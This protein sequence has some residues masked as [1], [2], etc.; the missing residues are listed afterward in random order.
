M[1]SKIAMMN[2]L[3]AIGSKDDNGVLTLT[4]ENIEMFMS[5]KHIRGR[6]AEGIK[7][8]KSRK[9]SGYNLFMRES[10]M[11]IIETA[12]KW[13]GLSDEE[14]ESFNT[15]A[16]DMEPIMKEKVVKKKRGGPRGTSSYHL[17][18]KENREQFRAEFPE[19]TSGKGAIQKFCAKR[20]AQLK[21]DN[22]PIVDKF[23][24]LALE[25]RE[26]AEEPKEAEEPEEPEEPKEPEEPEDRLMSEL[27]IQKIIE[28][29][30]RA[31]QECIMEQSES[32]S[33]EAEEPKEAEA[34]SESEGESE[35]EAESESE[36]ETDERA[37]IEHE[38]KKYYV[39]EEDLVYENE[40][41]GEP[42]GR[43]EDGILE[44][45]D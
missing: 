12:Q 4:P 21:E 45:L 18:M 41:N 29:N 3:M 31:F 6:D 1:A 34:E 16:A 9:P 7:E 39:D 37:E 20:W 32:K 44:F 23:E 25:S 15:R 30:D 26:E 5:R 2:R 43:Y 42:I 28:D 13:K 19:E 10:Q 38:G 24:K 35:S 8:R 11:S 22:D 14:R 33:E 27:R 17:F 40:E 36:E